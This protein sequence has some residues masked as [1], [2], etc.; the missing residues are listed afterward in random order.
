MNYIKYIAI[1]A[2]ATACTEHPENAMKLTSE[3]P[4]YPDYKGVTIPAG[5]APMNFNIDGAEIVD[6]SVK[7]SIVGEM[8]ANGEWADFDIEEWHNITEQNK[9]GDLVFRV[10]AK[11]DGK[12]VE[13]AD[14]KMHVSNDPLD[15]YGL[16][17]RKLAPGYEVFSDI[18][19]YQR[20]IH[21]FD[22]EAILASTAVPGQCMS[23][24]TANRTNPRQLTVHLR[25]KHAA[26]LV[27]IDGKRT[28]LTTK[29]DS[30]I[31]NCMYPYWHPSGNY[32]A[33]SLNKVHQSF[34]V[35]NKR[36]IEVF[37]DASDATILDV[38][39]NELILSP[40]LQTKDC[41]TYPTFSADGKTIYYCT[42][43]AHRVPAECEKMRYDLCTIDFDAESG[44]V[45]NTVDT[46]LKVSDKGHS[47]TFPR[48]SYDG[49]YLMYCLSDF[50]YF[51]I[52]HKES[53]LWLMDLRS[54]ETRA[55]DEVNSEDT[56]SFHNWS[57]N[58][59][60]FVF[61]SR[62]EDG[63]Y[64]LLYIANIDS[65]GNIGKPFVMPQRNPR[66]YYR[67]S[68]HSYNVPDFTLTK[69]ELDARAAYEEVFSDERI[70]VGIKK[71]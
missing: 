50:G 22:E 59:H 56:E 9:G 6:V 60:W 3:P 12:W 27:Q 4:I 23:C 47:I 61:S 34:Y 20:D 10:S 48:P 62:R 43:K 26:T 51:P 33:Y 35:G 32:C 21:T 52:D 65:E 38:R 39:T 24:H 42:S 66:E 11:N 63:Q 15:D 53:D 8:H 44:R 71:Q 64:S 17:Y 45:G 1:M 46:I 70:Q 68:L 29:T 13:Y 67:A 28:W 16:T 14:F 49:K 30:T 2:I 37:D 57:S 54:G 40:L 31:C 58:S 55:I 19:N 25:G 18:G 41:E 5:I 69:V 7:G 36:F